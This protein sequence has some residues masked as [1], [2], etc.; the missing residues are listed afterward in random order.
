M[1]GN[2]TTAVASGVAS[3]SIDVTGPVVSVLPNKGPTLA[4]RTREA[5]KQ[6]LRGKR[7]FHHLIAQLSPQ[8]QKPGHL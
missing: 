7:V 6:R 2:L 3:A 5:C 4:E 8:Q 1:Y